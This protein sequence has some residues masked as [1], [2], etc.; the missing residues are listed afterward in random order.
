M[1]EARADTT[2]CPCQPEAQPAESFTVIMHSLVVDNEIQFSAT[3]DIE[4]A[5]ATLGGRLRFLGERELNNRESGSVAS[6]PLDKHIRIV[7]E[8]EV[9][10]HNSHRSAPHL[11]MR[12]FQRR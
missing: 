9:A 5:A 6:K 1:D 8:E 2:R 3:L 10:D 11:D 12:F 7:R 4:H